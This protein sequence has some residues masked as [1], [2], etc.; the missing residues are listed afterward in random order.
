MI[1]SINNSNSN[2]NS[3]SINNHYNRNNENEENYSNNKLFKKYI[4]LGT[5]INLD[6]QQQQQQQQKLQRQQQQNWSEFEAARISSS[7][8][9]GGK[10]V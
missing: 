3:N 4:R 7:S 8:V 9:I 6:Q 2:S 5:D 1:E 10:I